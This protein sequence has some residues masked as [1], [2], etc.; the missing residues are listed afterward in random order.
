MLPLSMF[1]GLMTN[2]RRSRFVLLSQAMACNLELGLRKV[3]HPIGLEFVA[4]DRL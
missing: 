1:H 2:V 4:S 3:I